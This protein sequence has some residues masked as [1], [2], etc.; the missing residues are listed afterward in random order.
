MVAETFELLERLTNQIEAAEAAGL[1]ISFGLMVRGDPHDPGKGW[2]LTVHA[3]PPADGA[4]PVLGLDPDAP[5]V[6]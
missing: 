5:A 6:G 4:P 2:T 3:D 1:T